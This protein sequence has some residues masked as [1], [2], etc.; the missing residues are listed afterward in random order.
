MTYDSG[1]WEEIEPTEQDVLESGISPGVLENIPSTQWNELRKYS[2]TI[3]FRYLINLN[4][5]DANLTVHALHA[6]FDMTGEWFS[7]DKGVDYKYS[8]PDNSTIKVQILKNG[9]YKINY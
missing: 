3:R 2:D 9:D 4:E 8:Y 6:Q 5:E 1:M 7:A